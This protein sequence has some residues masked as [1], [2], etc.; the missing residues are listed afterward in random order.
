M[1]T[2]SSTKFM[3]TFCSQGKKYRHLV[4]EKKFDPWKKWYKTTEVEIFPGEKIKMKK[5]EK[6]I[7]DWTYPNSLWIM[8]LI[9][10]SFEFIFH[11]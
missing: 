8:D 9:R 11:F 10:L 1:K 3:E 2:G 5:L 6:S 7:Y 4:D